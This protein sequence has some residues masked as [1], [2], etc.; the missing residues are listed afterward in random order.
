MELLRDLGTPARECKVKGICKAAMR[1]GAQEPLGEAGKVV[2]GSVLGG[3]WHA[4][5][6]AC[7]WEDSG[8]GQRL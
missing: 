7:G 1:P 4:V 6:A 8:F 2:N 5:S 3:A